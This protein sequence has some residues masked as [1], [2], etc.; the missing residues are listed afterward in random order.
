MV[1]TVYAAFGAAGYGVFAVG[2][3]TFLIDLS[4]EQSLVGQKG[5]TMIT[6][7]KEN[8]RSRRLQKMVTN[9]QKNLR[10]RGFRIPKR[11]DGPE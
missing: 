4:N 11:P 3:L 10:L 1:T 8:P 2:F 7:I 5:R 9:I 6:N